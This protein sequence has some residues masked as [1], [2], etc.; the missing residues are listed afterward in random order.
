MPAVFFGRKG[1]SLDPLNLFARQLVNSNFSSRF[2]KQKSAKIDR[3]LQKCSYL[4]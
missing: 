4:R 1:R 2:E 3:V